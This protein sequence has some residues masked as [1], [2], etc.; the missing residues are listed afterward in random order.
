MY[1]DESGDCGLVNSPSRYFVLTGLIVHETQWQLCLDKLIM[2][3]KKIK[4]DFGLP[5]RA[6]IHTYHFLSR[7]GKFQYIKKHNR[8][9]IIRL[10]ADELA[11]MQE[12]RII[13]IVVDKQN[14]TPPY[15]VFEKS[16]T[17]LLQRFE[18]TITWNN[19]PNKAHSKEQGLILPDRTDNKK[20]TRLIRRM[21]KFNPVPNQNS[22]EPGYRNLKLGRILEDPNFKDSSDSYFTQAADLLAYLLQQKLSPNSYMKKKSGQNYFNRLQNILCVDACRDNPQG[23]VML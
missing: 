19:F 8:L 20:L 23:I 12:L 4:N 1:I 22:F 13:N 7:P 3:R 21:R 2:L 5:M 11:K 10:I 17:Y 15:D 9:A 16:W 18:N 14:K 6:E